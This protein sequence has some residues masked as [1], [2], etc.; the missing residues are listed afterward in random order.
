MVQRINIVER[1]EIEF[2][3]GRKGH[4]TDYIALI[5]PVHLLEIGEHVGDLG[6]Q[7]GTGARKQ[8]RSGGTAVAHM[9]VVGRIQV[10][11][12]L[13]THDDVHVGNHRTVDVPHHAAHDVGFLLVGEADRLSRRVERTE[14]LAG[15]RLGEHHIVARS[16]HLFAVAV[17]KL[18][19]EDPEEGRIGEKDRGRILLLTDF[20]GLRGVGR[21][22][23]RCDG[24][25]RFDFGITVAQ[26]LLEIIAAV[27]ALFGAN[28]IDAFGLGV[29]VVA[30]KLPQGVV[31]DQDH[32]HQRDGQPEDID[33]RIELVA[34][35]KVEKRAEIEL[36]EH[37]IRF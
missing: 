32:E 2:T 10:A 36:T 27:Q 5:G 12:A 8:E 35:Q 23:R 33:G 16:E 21:L 37:I 26:V 19:I 9:F 34:P 25:G 31:G 18:I 4:L 22:S 7:V 11:K 6:R 14:N 3:Q 30:R 17:Q 28:G 20:D 29:V 15:E 1:G 13:G 24:A